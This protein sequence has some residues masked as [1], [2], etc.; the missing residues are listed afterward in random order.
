[1]STVAGVDAIAHVGEGAACARV[2]SRSTRA[3]RAPGKRAAS[4]RSSRCVPWPS[5]HAG[6]RCRTSGHAARQRARRG[7]NDGSAAPAASRCTTSRAL[8]RGQPAS[9]AARRADERRREA[10]AVDEHERLLA[11]R[12]PRRD[13][14]A[15]AARRC[16][17]ARAAS[18]FGDER[19]RAAARRADRRASR[20]LEPA[21]AARAARGPAFRARRRAAEHDRHAALPRAPDRD[22][23]ARGSARRP[24]AC[25]TRSCS[26]STTMSAEPRQRREHREPRA[27]HERRRRRS[28]P[29]SQCASARRAASP[30]CSVDRAR[31]GQR[32]ARRA[33]RAA[34]SG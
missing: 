14:L 23:A 19:G 10:A 4:A 11:A 15:A 34:A 12:E 20:Q 32:V 6:R 30:L 22:V 21:V 33:R 31:A 27:E 5:G 13:R 28:P 8:Q 16:R 18:R 25:T 3:M 24:A 26:S 17:R 7:R 2:L 9:H 1:M 29:R